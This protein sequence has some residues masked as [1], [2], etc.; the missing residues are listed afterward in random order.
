MR[1]GVVNVYTIGA[2][3]LFRK[4]VLCLTEHILQ[5]ACSFR[6]THSAERAVQPRAQRLHRQPLLR[7]ASYLNYLLQLL[8]LFDLLQHRHWMSALDALSLHLSSSTYTIQLTLLCLSFNDPNPN[9]NPLL[10]NLFP[11]DIITYPFKVERLRATVAT[12]VS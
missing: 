2:P 7:T 1:V 5:A 6:V 11:S 4:R 12:A 3:S 9:P 8:H 10:S